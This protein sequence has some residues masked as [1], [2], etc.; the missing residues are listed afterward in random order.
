[1]PEPFKNFVGPAL[2]RTTAARFREV[3]PAFPEKRFLSLATEGLDTL[4]LK[5]RIRRFAEALGATLP[6]D[7]DKAAG[8][9]EASLAPISRTP[10]KPEEK[11]FGPG[12]SGWAVWP[13]TEYVA[14]KGIDHPERSFACMHALT[15]RASCEFA[16]R[17]FLV[18]YPDKTL[19]MLLRWA[20]DPNEDVR[21]LASEGSRPRLPWGL[22]LQSFVK[23]PSPCLPILDLLHDD[24]SE[25][26]RRSVAN[27]LNDISKDHPDLAAK[28]AERW[29]ADGKA[30]TRKLVS[31]ALRSLVK[32][33]HASSLALLGFGTAKGISVRRFAV[34]PASL[35]VGEKLRLDFEVA[36]AGKS[37]NSLVIDYA[38]HLKKANGSLRPK[39]FKGTKRVLAPG[40]TVALSL[41]HAIREVTVR[42]Y[43]AGVQEIELL[44]NGSVLAKGSFKLK[45]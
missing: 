12:L 26:V 28:T 33:G 45:A 6:A 19:A 34:S 25:T 14:A 2:A 43:H 42:T 18:K 13:L 17:P 23:D 8:L 4:E 31:H 10:G 15:Q 20:K 9:L 29:L 36:N 41:N 21:R 1:M 35:R 11:V 24:P 32:S 38:V 5:D 27:H 30:T 22:R 40:E 16:I 3:W 44:V 7:F 37:P 39:V